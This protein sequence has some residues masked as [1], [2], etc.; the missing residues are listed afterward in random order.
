M[1]RS[2]RTDGFVERIGRTLLVEHFRITRREKWYESVDEIQC[3]LAHTIRFYNLNTAQ[4]RRLNG[5]TPAQALREVIDR[6]KPP[7]IIPT[8]GET[9]EDKPP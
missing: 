6:K 3:D 9:A 4:S 8:E 1:L 5:R 2:P 7:P